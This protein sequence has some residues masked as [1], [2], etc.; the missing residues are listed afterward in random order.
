MKAVW[1]WGWRAALALIGVCT[2][3]QPLQAS[4]WIWPDLVASGPC[5]QTLQA[6]VDNAA[7]GDTILIGNDSIAVPDRYTGISGDLLIT[8]SLSL[9]ATAGIDAVF[10]S[11][12]I[13]VRTPFGAV[14]DVTLRGLILRAGRI[15]VLVFPSTSATVNVEQN[16]LSNPPAG[17]C[18]I[19]I[20]PQETLAFVPQLTISNNR[21]T[22]PGTSAQDFGR[23]GICIHSYANDFRADVFG[24]VVTALREHVVGIYAS[25]GDL[26]PGATINLSRNRVFLGGRG[27]GLR[28]IGTNAAAAPQVTIANNIVVG[29]GGS[30]NDPAAAISILHYAAIAR[31]INN[32]LID[33][34][35][36]VRVR[37]FGTPSGL[38]ARVANNLIS[39]ARVR[40]FDFLNIAVAND[41][42]LLHRVADHDLGPGGMFGP[43]TLSGDP[44]L[45]RR[46]YPRAVQQGAP[47]V[48]A[49]DGAAVPAFT[50]FDA[51]GEKR[52]QGP[53]DIGALE[54]SYDGARVHDATAGNT[55]GNETALDADDYSFPL[56]T[57]D[58]LVVS[59]LRVAAGVS[60]GSSHLGV[61]QS[62]VLARRWAIFHQ[63][64]STLPTGRRY[65]VLLPWDSRTAI[66]HTVAAGNIPVAAT[67]E[68]EI[69][70]PALNNQAAA[71]AV[72]TP[73]WN[74]A[75]TVS[76]QYH[77]HPITLVYRGSR[78]RIRN[79]DAASMNSAIGAAFNLAVAPLFSPNAFTAELGT[80]AA[81]EIPL[82][83]PL[84][85]DNPCAAPVAS[86]R[87]QLGDS[88]LTLN[89]TP[90]ALEYRAPLNGF[91]V[92]RWYIVKEGPLG[93]AGRNAFNVV[94]DGAQAQRCLAPWPDD[95]FADGFD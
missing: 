43:G 48:D 73:N 81:D 46:E 80:S 3:A 1:T 79:D 29:A 34:G 7:S 18:A 63:D 10:E 88:L 42:N 61:Y 69:D 32:S 4:T 89:D 28:T 60:A 77:D 59:P 25:A 26:A 20:A 39:G 50:L 33:S 93:F 6:C 37:Q 83:H 85:D 65:A 19:Q 45:E 76:G 5:S 75:N 58:R 36:A 31:V 54:F 94:V 8:K 47:G 95:L 38:D 71:I 2:A 17:E 64:L 55:F 72:V 87:V 15:Q 51:D 78:W 56:F 9:V 92:G 30:N 44:L 16:V 14:G 70:H 82:A 57:T 67:A 74:P 90:F 52:F 84:L 86:R 68:T 41:H 23:N 21:V 40:G 24:N 66:L 12:S 91:D 35:V 49:G 27:E 53:V 11:G 22:I 62:D 13:F